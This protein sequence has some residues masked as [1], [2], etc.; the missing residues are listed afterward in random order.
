MPIKEDFCKGDKKPI[1]KIALDDGE[2]FHWIWPSQAGESGNDWD[3]SKDE[4]VL[5]DYKKHGEK[6]VKIFIIIIH[7]LSNWFFVSSTEVLFNWH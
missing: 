5:A 4:K 7:D 1:G 2:N 3:A 6:M